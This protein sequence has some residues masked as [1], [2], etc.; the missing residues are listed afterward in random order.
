MKELEP[1]AAST[2]MVVEDCAS[3]MMLFCDLLERVGFDTLRAE[4]GFHAIRLARTHRPDLILLDIKLPDI[5]GTKV[6]R[7]FRANEYLRDIPI[8]AVTAFAMPGDRERILNAGFDAYVSKPI[9]VRDFLE[10][11]ER[12]VSAKSLSF[13]ETATQLDARC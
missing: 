12:F 8:V 2:I 1:E 11:V 10:V 13:G 7:W 4:T 3:N 6:A 5:D 9:S